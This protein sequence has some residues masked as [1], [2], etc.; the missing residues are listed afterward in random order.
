MSAP[1]ETKIGWMERC[2]LE[3]SQWSCPSCKKIFYYLNDHNDE[4]PP[5]FCPECGRQNLRAK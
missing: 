2:S 1:N 5:K 3:V 4:L